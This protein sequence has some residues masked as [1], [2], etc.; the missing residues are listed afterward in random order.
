[1]GLVLTPGD[2]L[3]WAPGC[4]CS[5]DGPRPTPLP[6]GKPPP[7]PGQADSSGDL[8][9]YVLPVDMTHPGAGDVLHAAPTHPHL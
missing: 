9:G 2:L 1:M 4:L 6:P 7:Y 5:A 3:A 8:V